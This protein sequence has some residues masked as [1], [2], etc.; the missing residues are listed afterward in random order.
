V[1]DL[2]RFIGNSNIE[3]VKMLLEKGADITAATKDKQTSLYKASG[4]DY[5]EIAKILLEK[6]ADI[7]IATKDK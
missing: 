4:N 6:G 3:I 2:V 1:D 7:I 5:L